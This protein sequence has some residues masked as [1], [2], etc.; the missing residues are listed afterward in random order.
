VYRR[1]EPEQDLPTFAHVYSEP[2]FTTGEGG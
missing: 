1:I 2:V